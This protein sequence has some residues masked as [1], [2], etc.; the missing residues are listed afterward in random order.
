MQHSDTMPAQETIT[1]GWSLF[2]AIPD[3]VHLLDADGMIVA[4]NRNGMR[5]LE[6]DNADAPLGRAW[7][8]LWP[9]DTRDVVDAALECARAGGTGHLQ[10]SFPTATGKQKW[11]D[12]VLTRTASPDGHQA[13]LLAILRDITDQV[14]ADAERAALA[15]QLQAASERSRRSSARPPPA[16]CRWIPKAASR[17]STSAIATWWT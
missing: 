14:T 2:E 6:V 8:S 11:W 16:W 17:W 3:C 12:V 1:L 10:A 13:H 9:L 5:A 15:R 7:R 4:M